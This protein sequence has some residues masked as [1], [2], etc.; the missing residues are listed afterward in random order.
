M[1]YANDS[2]EGRFLRGDPDAVGTVSRWVA[3][4]LTDVRFWGLN[5]EWLDLHQETMTLVL[6]SLRRER[7]DVTRDFRSYVQAIARYTLRRTGGDRRKMA[8]QVLDPHL[9]QPAPHDLAGTVT[10]RL[11]VARVLSELSEGCRVLIYQYFYEERSYDE[12]ASSAGLPVGTVKSRLFR[13]LGEARRGLGR[14][15]ERLRTKRQ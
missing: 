15:R 4:V 5:H 7:F 14:R 1:P 10:R 9:E 2:T 12:I 11:L 6:E 13:C 3:A 8:V